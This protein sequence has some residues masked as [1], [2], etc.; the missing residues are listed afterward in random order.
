MDSAV[1]VVTSWR[2]ELIVE[3]EEEEEGD[4]RRGFEEASPLSR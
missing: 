1:N 4:V 3:E 2:T